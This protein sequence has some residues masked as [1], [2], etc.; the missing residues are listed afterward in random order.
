MCW[1]VF[2]GVCV[3]ACVYTFDVM[4]VHS[5]AAMAP[6]LTP[7]APK[8]TLSQFRSGPLSQVVKEEDQI[9]CTHTGREIVHFF[10]RLANTD[11]DYSSIWAFEVILEL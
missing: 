4:F 7:N 5:A 1:G 9:A 8:K 2:Q 3:C 11:S 10:V 6:S